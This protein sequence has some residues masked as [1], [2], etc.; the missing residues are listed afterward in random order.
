MDIRVKL[1]L[2]LVF[3]FSLLMA[4]WGQAEP[5]LKGAEQIQPYETEQGRTNTVAP[6]YQEYTPPTTNDSL[7]VRNQVQDVKQSEANRV[8]AQKQNPKKGA[9]VGAAEA[10]TRQHQ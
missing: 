8:A 2:L 5:F 3:G 6:S 4:G 7:G 9:G 1:V 10:A